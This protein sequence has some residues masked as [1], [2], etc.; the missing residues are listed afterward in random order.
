MFERVFGRRST[1]SK[2]DLTKDLK[3]DD[4]KTRSLAEIIPA[5]EKAGDH[6]QLRTMY[7]L[8]LRLIDI[9]LM[10]AAASDADRAAALALEKVVWSEF[11]KVAQDD[12]PMYEACVRS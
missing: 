10:D 4:L 2:L 3:Y 5:A 8:S 6:L 12:P 1:T 11:E 7:S 9:A